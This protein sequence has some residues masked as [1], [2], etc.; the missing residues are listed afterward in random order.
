MHTPGS[1]AGPSPVLPALRTTQMLVLAD[2]TPAIERYE[3]LGLSRISTA[4]DGCVGMLAGET[5]VILATAEF[6]TGDFGEDATTA[7]L[8]RAINYL[9]VTSVDAAKANLSPDAV[10][11]KDAVTRIGT[12]ELLVDDQGELLILA[13]LS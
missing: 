8:G 11:L 13:E 2:I 6:M 10:V 9:R 3:R 12:R 7:I 5:G 4:D 1:L